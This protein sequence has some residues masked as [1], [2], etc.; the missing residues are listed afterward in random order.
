M[1]KIIQ[2]SIFL[3]FFA[4]A[5]GQNLQFNV[6]NKEYNSFV[7][8]VKNSNEY[9]VNDNYLQAKVKKFSIRLYD[10]GFNIA[11]IKFDQKKDFDKLVSEIIKSSYFD[12]RYCKSYNEPI[13]YLFHSNIGNKYS[14]SSNEL[15]ISVEYPTS[16]SQFLDSNNQ[17]L[18]VFVCNSD[19]SYAYHTNLKCG[20]LNNCTKEI[21]KAIILEAKKFG[22]KTICE[23][24]SKL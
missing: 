15:Q 4:V 20:N 8:E 7:R 19:N 13:T 12:Y 18:T 11:I 1:K 21:N 24:C 5:N 17:H 2:L 10:S 9:F 16:T 6:L 22:Y 14:F 3:S 23:V